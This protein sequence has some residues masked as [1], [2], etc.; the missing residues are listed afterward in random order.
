MPTRALDDILNE[1]ELPEIHAMTIDVEGAEAI[2]LQGLSLTRH[3]PWVLCI[4]AV[5]PGTTTPSHSEWE[6]ALLAHDYTFVVF[7]GVNRW[8]VANEHADL[9]DALAIPVNAIDMGEHGWVTADLATERDHRERSVARRAWQRELILN[10][11]RGEVPREEYER[12]IAELRA[13]LV[14]V[15]GSRTWRYA[16]KAAGAAKRIRHLGQRAMQHLPGPAA[17]ALVRQRHL[18]HVT[19]NMGHLTPAPFLAADPRS[20]S[21]PIPQPAVWISPDGLP[22]APTVSLSAPTSEDISAIRE[23]L[24]T[25]PFDTDEMLVRRADNRGDEVGRAMAAMRTRAWPT[26]LTLTGLAV[27]WCYWMHDA[28]RQ[29]RSALAA[30]AALHGPPCSRLERPWAMSD[31]S[32]S[33][34]AGLKNCPKSLPAHAARSPASASGLCRRSAY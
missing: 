9:A 24:A 8:Y 27:I 30:S 14:S 18:R 1:H 6:P 12:Q 25:G 16:R 22:P 4:E 17:S 21:I 34:I 23:W 20:A 3:R 29:Q 19:I 5:L 2:V 13:A 33:S 11:I 28:C 26:P 31:L 7:D 15:E 10:D 32:C